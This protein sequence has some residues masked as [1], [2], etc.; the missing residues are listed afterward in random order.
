MPKLS[1]SRLI[2]HHFDLLP[3][4]RN[5][6]TLPDPFWE[7]YSQI[8]A[9]ILAAAWLQHSSVLGWSFKPLLKCP[10][11]NRHE[12]TQDLS[13]CARRLSSANIP[14]VHQSLLPRRY[15]KLCFTRH[16]R[17]RKSSKSLPWS[18]Q[19]LVKNVAKLLAPFCQQNGL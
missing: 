5:F 6:P 19:D 11:L 16:Q 13:Q 14:K 8:S 7:R 9:S 12:H 3:H 4:L 10:V 18:S 2:S 17:K 15:Y 1:I